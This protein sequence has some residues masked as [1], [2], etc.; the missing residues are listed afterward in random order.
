MDGFRQSANWIFMSQPQAVLVNAFV[1]LLLL[2]YLIL[3]ANSAM[4]A[5]LLSTRSHL[6]VGIIR[7]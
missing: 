4:T 2:S 1:M 7:V 5:R 3:K 6:S